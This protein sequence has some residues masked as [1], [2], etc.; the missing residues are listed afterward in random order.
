MTQESGNFSPNKKTI[1][2]IK[3]GF[4][5][6]LIYFTFLMVSKRLN[7]SFLDNINLPI[8]EFGHVLFTP[9]GELMHF[10]GGSITQIVFPAVFVVAF[11]LKKDLFAVGVTALWTG[12]SMINVSYYAADAREQSIPLIGGQHDWACILSDLNLLIYDDLIGGIFFFFGSMIMIAGLLLAIYSLNKEGK[13]IEIKT[14]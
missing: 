9:F 12:E 11:F 8:H 3:S 10:L 5:L 1:I 14:K 6:L 13:F 7:Y 4:L 2:F